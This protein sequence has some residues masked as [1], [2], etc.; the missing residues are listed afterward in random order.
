VPIRAEQK[1]AAMGVVDGVDYSRVVYRPPSI[2][3]KSDT[4]EQKAI[5]LDWCK[6]N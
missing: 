3:L 5:Y 6:K 1:I 4:L 2:W